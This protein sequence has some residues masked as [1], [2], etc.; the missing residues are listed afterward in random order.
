MRIRF[1]VI[2]INHFHIYRMTQA[3]LG[4]GGELTAYFAPDE[5]WAAEYGKAYPSARRVFDQREILEDE[6]LQLVLSAGIPSQRAPLGIEVMRHGKD[7]L[8]D[9]A[10]F[11]NLDDLAEARRVQAETGRIFSISYSERLLEKG[12]WRAGELVRQGAIGRVLQTVIVAP[13]DLKRI[14]RPPWFFERRHYGGILTD[15]GSH[16]IEQFLY[17]SRLE[18]AE[19]VSAQVANYCHPQH[20]E[21][22]DFGEVLLR[23][24]TS[25]GQPCSAYIRV[26]WLIPEGAKS[27]GRHRVLLGSEGVLELEHAALS[28]SNSQGTER[29]DCAATELPFGQLLVDDVINRTQTAMPQQHCFYASE[30]TIRAQMQATRHGHLRD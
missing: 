21:F 3:V 4:G 11:L 22:E 24:Q 20:G 6:S 27:S 1:A 13:H 23:G 26:D 15:I 8:C 2:G 30:L 28:L 12:S 14:T 10:G 17:Y 16:Q 9:K 7:Y 25:D 29:I 19:I 18:H 5:A